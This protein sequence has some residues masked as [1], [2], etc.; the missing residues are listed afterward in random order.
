MIY[1]LKCVLYLYH[2]VNSQ[3]VSMYAL[4]LTENIWK[5]KKK[6]NDNAKNSF[7]NNIV[8]DSLCAVRFIVKISK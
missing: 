6:K 4:H 3:E 1:F 7:K 2:D 5:K 8:N